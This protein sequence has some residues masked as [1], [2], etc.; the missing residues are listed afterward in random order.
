MWVMKKIEEE[1]TSPSF[2]S[3]KLEG[4]IQFF[5]SGKGY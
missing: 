2:Q 5:Q 3:E 1:L 4:Q